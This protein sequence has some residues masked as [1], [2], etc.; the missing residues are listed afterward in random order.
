MAETQ[1]ASS[2]EYTSCV[3]LQ[4]HHLLSLLLQGARSKRENQGGMKE[5][6]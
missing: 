4:T 6:G 5:P 1:T 2:V 3:F